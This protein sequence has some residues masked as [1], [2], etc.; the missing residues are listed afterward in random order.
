MI[1]IENSA[2]QIASAADADDGAST[3]DPGSSPVTLVIQ[4]EAWR[5]L[6][7]VD[8]LVDRA[9]TAVASALPDT[10]GRE[11]AI[12]L[13]GDADLRALNAQFRGL[14]KPTNVLSFPHLAAPGAPDDDEASPLGDIVIAYETVMRE[15]EEDCKPPLHH[16]AHMIVHGLLH[17]AGFDHEDDSE[18]A[19]ME[20][21][22]RAIL[23]DMGIADPYRSAA[24]E[25]PL[26]GGCAA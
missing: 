21:L 3:D 26:T 20:A 25:Q 11:V 4:D 1:M 12:V 15:A 6:D 8:T 23:A 14:D 7:G 19:E 2:C 22:E 13:A 17:L 24:D 9:V 5:R 16:L 18:A 10:A